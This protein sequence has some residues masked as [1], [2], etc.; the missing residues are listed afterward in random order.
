MRDEAAFVE[1]AEAVRGTAASYGVPAVRGLGPGVGP[2]PGG[3][4]P[5]LRRLAAARRGPAAS[6]PTPGRPWSAPSSTTRGGGRAPSCPQS[7]TANVPS[8]AGRRRVRR[9]ARRADGGPRRRC[10][11]GSGPAWCCATS[12]TSASPTRPP[13]SGAARARSRARRR[14]AL[15]S[16]RSM[17]E[18][19][20]VGEP[21]GRRSNL[22]VNEL[23]ELLSAQRRRTAPRRPSTSVRS[24]PAAGAGCAAAGSPSSAVR[25]S[26]TA[27]VAAASFALL[28]P[29]PPDLAAAGVPRPGRPDAAAGRRHAGGRGRGLPGAGVARRT[30]TSTATTA[31]TSTASPTTGSSCSATGR[32]WTSCDRASPSWT[33][34][35]ARRTG[36][37][38]STSARR[39]RGRSSSARTG[40]CCCARSTV[41]G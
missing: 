20:P 16:L 17:F 26:A 14:A 22:M 21:R 34:P 11:R 13:S 32:G 30:R 28:G 39:R 3:A 6:T 1:F 15:A 7:P 27:A 41:T 19:S 31:S 29:W 18:G 2:R 35:P 38:T 8:R 23:R 10:R 9:L 33:R 25:R 40:W 24:S 37:P 36:C 5:G 12:R 4:D